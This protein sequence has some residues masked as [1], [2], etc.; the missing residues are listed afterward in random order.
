MPKEATSSSDMRL[1]LLATK[2]DLLATKLE[3]QGADSDGKDKPKKPWWTVTV[4]ILALPALIVAILFQ[5][6]QTTANLR[7]PEKT[8]AETE[9]LRTEELKIRADLALQHE[10]LSEKK[11]QGTAAYRSELEKA[12]PRL[13]ETITKLGQVQQQSKRWAFDHALVKYLLLWTVFM[14]IG[15]FFDI[16]SQIW[17]ALISSVRNTINAVYLYKHISG[18]GP[19]V[20]KRRKRQDLARKVY[21][22]LDSLL[23]PVPHL[24]NWAVR[25]SI[26][27]AIII[28]FFNEMAAY[29]GSKDTFDSLL[30]SARQLN[31]GE[32][33]AKL[34]AILGR[35]P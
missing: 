17:H 31:V 25:I 14:G 3:R 11:G 18:T 4:E 19:E 35:N 24:L 28:P 34:Q 10:T 33:I 13:E 29:L 8:A 22:F 32:A 5:F 27:V 20:E 12:L 2:I 7:T 30:L 21:P 9:K 15:L 26:F 1:E 23:Y 6:T 16:V